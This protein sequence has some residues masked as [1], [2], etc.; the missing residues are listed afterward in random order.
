M[1]RPVAILLAAGRGTR[2]GGPKALLAWPGATKGAP[3]RPLVIAH[4]EAR[5][6]AESGRVLIVAR[7]QVITTLIGYVRPGLDLLVSHAD[8]ELGPAGSLAVAVSRLADTD[9]AIVSPVDVPPASAATVS[10]LLAR[11]EQGEPPPRAVRPRHEGRGGHPIVIRVEALAR[12]REPTPPPLRDHLRELGEGVVDE[13]VEDASVLA[14]LD[15][16]VDLLRLTGAP[17]RFLG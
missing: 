16:P 15:K 12:Y 6:A 7:Q 5:L 17:P 3:E 13:D 1:S 9:I 2:I 10:R 11:L 4:A 14:D 8:D